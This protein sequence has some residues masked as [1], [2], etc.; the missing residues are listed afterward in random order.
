MK[1]ICIY[2]EARLRVFLLFL[3]TVQ[4]CCWKVNCVEFQQG[5]QKD[6]LLAVLRK[7]PDTEEKL[8]ALSMLAQISWERPEE[9]GFQIQLM[10]TA[11]SVDSMRYS[12]AALS[13]LGRYYCNRNNPDSLLYWGGVF[14]SITKVRHVTPPE[15]FDFLNYYC[16]YYL[17]NGE[18]ELA[19]NEAVKLQMLSD[20]TGELQGAISSNEYL[21]LIYLLIGRDGDAAAAFEQA[22]ELL[23]KKG[24]QADY[25]VQII[26]YLLIAYERLGELDKVAVLLEYGKGL[27]EEIGR[28]ASGRWA[29]YPVDKKYCI[30]YSHYINLYVAQEKQGEAAEALRT[31][32]SYA[33]KTNKK[34]PY[35]ISIY[36][37]AL[38]RYYFFAKDYPRAIK[39]IDNVLA[40]DYSVEPLKLK[41]EILKASDKKNEALV[42]HDQLLSFVEQTNTKAFTR[43]LNQLR[44]LHNL[45]EKKIQE[46]RL[47][48]QKEELKHKQN[49]LTASLFFF[50]LLLVLFYFLLRYAYRTRKLKEDLQRERNMLVETTGKLLISKEQAEEANRLKT[51]FVA[52]I[53]HEI[54]TPLNA[55]VGFS[56]LLEDADEEERKEFIGI[57]QNSSDLLLGLVN[58]VLDLSRLD[59]DTFTLSMKECNIYACCRNAQKSMQQRVKHGVALTL[60]CADKD[61]VMKTDSLRLQQLLLNLLTNA[62][63]CTEQGEINL[64]FRVDR[65]KR[66]VIFSVT[67]TGCGIPLDKQEIIFNRFEKVD[68][69]K[70]GAGL[71]LAICR[72]IADHFGGTLAVDPAYTAGARFV[73]VHPLVEE[74]AIKDQI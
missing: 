38:A 1:K 40:V 20:E 61:F 29:N 68:E 56:G 23:K 26:P 13:A 52:N 58:D 10:E 11:V 67:D 72:T 60:T 44:T 14:D 42:L 32:S 8:Q 73:F 15:S 21:G 19:M 55:I 33:E 24:E 5:L 45:N 51:A 4:T 53:S 74:E 27:I 35:L 6:S 34:D 48:Y 36:N 18:Y 47:V 50:F 2:A 57:I 66:Q 30:L 22:V 54:R 37:L 43:Q 9:V 39:E 49:Q 7:T 70:Q 28:N 17:M 31:A 12:Y 69:F 3:C 71:G 16:R 64:D 41:V 62:A 59:S 63:K 46:Q 25:E 65:E